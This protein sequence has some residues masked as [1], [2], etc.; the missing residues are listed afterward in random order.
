MNDKKG[1]TVLSGKDRLWNRMLWSGVLIVLVST[2]L[3]ASSPF[4]LEKGIQSWSE[5]SGLGKTTI[6][7]VQFNPLLGTLVLKGVEIRQQGSVSLAL[8]EARL[9]LDWLPLWQKR[10][11]VRDLSLKGLE[12]R[13]H[14]GEEG[15]LMVAGVPFGADDKQPTEPSG[16][17]V[18]LASI[19]VRSSE[20]GIELENLKQKL[21]IEQL[22]LKGLASWLAE[23]PAL[24]DFI[25]QFAGAGIDING[26]LLP[27]S[28]N[29]GGDLALKLSS[30]DTTI[31]SKAF[32]QESLAFSGV[33]SS[34]SKI[35]VSVGKEGY[36]ISQQGSYRLI[37]GQARFQE[38]QVEQERLAWKGDLSI[39][40]SSKAGLRVSANGGLAL[41]GT[42]AVLDERSILN[43][44]SLSLPGLSF[45]MDGQAFKAG[46]KG[47]IA[48]KAIETRLLQGQFSDVSINWNG[49]LNM[50]SKGDALS[51][52]MEGN[53]GAANPRLHLEQNDTDIDIRELT[54]SGSLTLDRAKQ[55]EGGA[56]LNLGSESELNLAQALLSGQGGE[57][58]GELNLLAWKGQVNI[59]DDVPNISGEL[60]AGEGFFDAPQAGYRMAAWKGV[61]LVQIKSASLPNIEIEG[62]DVKA[63]RLAEKLVAREAEKDTAMLSVEGC[64]IKQVKFD[65]EQGLSIEAVSPSDLMVRIARDTEGQWSP[66]Q[67][68]EKLGSTFAG[69]EEDTAETEPMTLAV[70]GIELQGDNKILL[71]DEK[72]KP[73]Y[74]GEFI[75]DQLTVG[76]VDSGKPA[77]P[78]SFNGN[79]RVGEHSKLDFNGEAYPF[80]EQRLGRFKL[81]VSALEIPPL[82]PYSENMLGYNLDSGQMDSKIELAVNKGK[83]DGLVKLQLYKLEVSPLDSEAR[84]KLESTMDVP[85]ATALDLL[86]DDQN[87]IKLDLP[88]AGDLDN[89]DF[90][91]SDAI[92]QATG[93]ALKKGAMIYLMAALQPFGAL[94]AIA[95]AAGDAASAVRLDP[96]LFEAGNTRWKQQTEP[97]LGKVSGV[98]K[99][100]PEL[101]TRVCG[102]ATDTDRQALMALKTEKIKQEQAAAEADQDRQSE[103]EAEQPLSEVTVDSEELKALAKERADK[104]KG[105]LVEQK[106]I[107]AG[108][109]ISCK[110]VED[111]EKKA[112]PR[113]DLLI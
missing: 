7:Q 110:P 52:H 83:L 16:W 88:I 55:E 31:V 82:S 74:K 11:S 53:L 90:D 61:Q 101:R 42:K 62:L 26:G 107:D 79:I 49:N 27:F 15:R 12:T 22:H 21:K 103:Q 85:L 29:P 111:K 68:A 104:V 92:N 80:A 81:D 45:R 89:P 13:I 78:V 40:H 9:W 25:G 24:L 19:K 65:Q 102:V 113:V 59:A 46:H 18:G 10:V 51:L 47:C 73:T 2:F 36:E 72:V 71:T 66:A 20:I 93:K 3:L 87:T 105:Y 1:K 67:V 99:E 94:I 97:Y 39:S 69:D 14:Q 28:D 30:L 58:H 44:E 41:Q 48:L 109:L 38:Q 17:G 8:E 70:G 106:A 64:A 75:I 57:I 108:R 50:L 35:K 60:S 23:E 100:R 63:L 54:W 76:K 95:S 32:N 4:F 5:K 96:I 112:E 6:E 43:L 77:Q 86:R 84:A 91:I 37:D 56:V 34:T 98:M 33:L